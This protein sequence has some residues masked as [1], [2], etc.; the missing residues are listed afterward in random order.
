M[1]VTIIADASFCPD[2]K[3]A[4]FGY[5]IASDRGK[6]GGGGA[7]KGTIANN[8]VA[9]MMAVC[10]GLHQA[11]FKGLVL[12]GDEVLLQ[13]DCRPALDAFARVRSKL[14]EAEHRV[15]MALDKLISSGN[16]DVTYRH[17]K[18]HSKD[19]ASRYVAN[20]CCDK[21]AKKHLR[22]ARGQVYIDKI[23]ETLNAT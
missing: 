21:R 18:G 1:R 7:L 5:W 22:K 17:V 12:A 14:S 2:L 13:S 9:E 15:V 19:K 6:T 23:K 16:L 11:I 10:N 8:V 3:V 20:E 4:G